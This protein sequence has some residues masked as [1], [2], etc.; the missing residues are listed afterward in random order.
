M[1]LIFVYGSLRKGQLNAKYLEKA[2]FLGLTQTDSCWSLYDLG[3]FPAAVQKGS[4]AIIGEV[5]A[6]D[7]ATLTALDRL[8]LCPDYFQRKQIETMYGNAWIYYLNDTEA[9]HKQINVGDWP[10]YSKERNA[11]ADFW[12]SAF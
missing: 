1:A 11:P 10:S 3:A 5:Y 8:E 9:G 12:F 7:S 2:E 6:I 4:T